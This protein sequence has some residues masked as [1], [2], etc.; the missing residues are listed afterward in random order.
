MYAVL[1]NMC[2]CECMTVFESIH[3]G[4]HYIRSR[5]ILLLCA[6]LMADYT[7]YCTHGRCGRIDWVRSNGIFRL[8]SLCFDLSLFCVFFFFARNVKHFCYLFWFCP[9][10]EAFWGQSSMEMYCIIG[11]FLKRTW[12]ILSTESVKMPFRSFQINFP[13]WK[14]VVACGFASANRGHDAHKQCATQLARSQ[15]MEIFRMWNVNTYYFHISSWKSFTAN[16]IHAHRCR[17]KSNA[18][19]LNVIGVEHVL[20]VM[21][22]HQHTYSGPQSRKS[23]EMYVIIWYI[24]KGMHTAHTHTHRSSVYTHV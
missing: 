15:F 18:G 14:F 19:V 9:L 21:C 24:D 22:V 11:I 13:K 6:R 10:G 16:R 12:L 1:G 8:S 4:V 2:V 3:K 5:L 20:Q 7:Y 23:P 17:T